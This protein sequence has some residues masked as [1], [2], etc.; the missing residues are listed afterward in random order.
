MR[1]AYEEYRAAMQAQP[2]PVTPRR[3]FFATNGGIENAVIDFPAYYA[4]DHVFAE[5]LLGLP[6]LRAMFDYAWQRSEFQLALTGPDPQRGTWELFVLSDLM[7]IPLCHALT[8]AGLD[9][10]SNTGTATPWRLS[11]E[12]IDRLTEQ[13]ITKKID[14]RLRFIGHCPLR[15]IRGDARFLLDH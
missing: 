11:G 1:S 8:Q 10:A 15:W 2:I 14:K 12:L 13:V 6:K 3:V 4:W 9:E 5:R 7:H